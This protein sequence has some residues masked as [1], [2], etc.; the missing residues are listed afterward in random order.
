MILT[1]ALCGLAWCLLAAFAPHSAGAQL[2]RDGSDLAA[3]RRIVERVHSGESYYD[4]AAGE[5]R[6][7][8]YCTGS[9]FNWRPP[10]YAWLIGRLPSPLW[11]QILLGIAASLTALMAY[12]AM[13]HEGGTWR[14]VSGL[15]LLLGAF[16]WCI[17]GDAFLAQ[18]LW[19]GVLIALSACAYA[20]NR[21]MLGVMA[22]LLALFF[23]ELAAPYCLISLILAWR[24]KRRQ[25]VAVWL[26]GFVAYALYLAFHYSMVAG[27]ITPADRV[28]SSWVQFGG[29]A[30]L[31]AT[32]RMN[33]FFFNAPAW[34]SAIYLSLAVLGLAAWRSQL[35]VRLGLT[36]GAYL[37]A[38]AIVGQPFNEYWGLLFA[39]LLP[40]GFVWAPA[41]LRDLIAAAAAGSATYAQAAKVR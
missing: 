34:A 28:P 16:L 5:L 19:A 23:R 12:G 8:G 21:W 35:G 6:A 31:L 25:E 4:A 40:F 33:A 37:A 9:R 39:P 30:F 41:A 2:R 24:W 17:D 38:F 22:G 29:P 7:A 20:S 11:A 32:C 26:A 13:K 18:E 10:L 1:A 3:Y 36:V 15:V 14:A 27:K